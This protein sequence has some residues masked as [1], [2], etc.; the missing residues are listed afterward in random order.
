MKR[1][2]MRA[3]TLLVGLAA[4]S[5]AVVESAPRASGQSGDGWNML[6]DGKTMDGWNQL[7]DTNWR[8]EDG[9]IVFA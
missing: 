4:A 3:F 2:S 9:A 7:G 8:I 1:T 5:I 6:F